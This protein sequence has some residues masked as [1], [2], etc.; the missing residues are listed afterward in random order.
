M[1]SGYVS[2]PLS[3]LG[4]ADHGRRGCGHV[5][6]RDRTVPRNRHAQYDFSPFPCLIGPPP[7]INL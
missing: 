2:S 3:T 1:K 4:E 5:D 7:Q 6:P